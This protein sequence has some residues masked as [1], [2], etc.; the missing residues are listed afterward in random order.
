MQSS[1]L[2]RTAQSPTYFLVLPLTTIPHSPFPMPHAPFPMPHAPCPMPHA[3]C[4]MPHAPCPMPHTPY[5][6]PHTPFDVLVTFQYQHGE[7]FPL[8]GSFPRVIGFQVRR[9]R[10]SVISNFILHKICITLSFEITSQI[11][12]LV[13]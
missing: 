9:K 2:C 3:P 10:D 4:P 13:Y 8:Q 6:I 1:S 7:K 12:Q 11:N 5:P